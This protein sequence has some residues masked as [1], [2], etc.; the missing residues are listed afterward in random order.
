MAI[1]LTEFTKIVVIILVRGARMKNK[2]RKVRRCMVILSSILLICILILGG[3]FVANSSG[4]PKPFL[5][6]NGKLLKDSISE[7]I[8]VTINGI[9]QGM[10]IKSKNRENPVL[11]FLHGGPGMPEYGVSRQYPNVLENLFT[12][13]WWEQRGAG[14]SYSSSIPIETMNFDQLILDTLEVTQYLRKRFS[15]EKIYLMAHS[16][17][18]FIGLQVVAKAPELYKA[19]I[20]MSQITN[21]LES[22]K[23]AYQY[24]VDQFQKLGDKKMLHQ[25]EKYPITDINTPS[26]YEMRDAP[27]HQ[28]GIGTTHK[29]RSVIRGVVLPIMQNQEYTMTEKI[30]IWRG[31]FFSTRTANLWGKLVEIDLTKRIESIRCPVYFFD[32]VFDYT[33]SYTLAKNYFKNLKAPLKGFY[34]FD[35]SAH[36]PLFEEPEK[37]ETILKEDVLKGSNKLADLR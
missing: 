22:E 28:L 26:Y 23:L 24:M 34:T 32:G 3:I 29:M 17:G 20:A 35:Q 12:V 5:D 6:E 15:Q 30:N 7:K 31:K 21:Q 27:M 33:V 11:L 16:G 8:F 25:F 14:L 13:C 18:S 1:I 10:F 2:Y 19:Y 36:S 9:R 37:M 4:R